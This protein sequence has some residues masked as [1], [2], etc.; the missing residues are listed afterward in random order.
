MSSGLKTKLGS[1]RGGNYE[2]SLFGESSRA[3]ALIWSDIPQASL[4]AG[5]VLV[6]VHATTVMPA[7]LQWCP[8]F[9]TPSSEPRSF[10]IVLSHEFSGVI[11]SVAVPVETL[12]PGDAVYGLNDWF[13]NDAQA[14]YCVAPAAMLAPKSRLTYLKNAVIKER[15]VRQRDDSMRD[16]RI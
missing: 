11:E 2:G 9:K 13:A 14:E 5:E 16:N 1:S 15:V 8:T 10:P 3:E 12:K 7:E 4:Q 6:K